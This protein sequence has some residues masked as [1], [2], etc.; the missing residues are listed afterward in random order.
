[1][2]AANETITIV[3]ENS[4]VGT[5]PFFTS[6]QCTYDR[7]PEKLGNQFSSLIK[8][9]GQEFHHSEKQR[10]CLLNISKRV[11]EEIQRQYICI[12]VN[13]T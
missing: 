1:M 12:P 2:E 13:I 6:V 9:K 7:V 8:Y 10:V 3:I 4:K 11:H 5:Q